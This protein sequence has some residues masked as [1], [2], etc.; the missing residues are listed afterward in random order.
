MQSL[1]LAPT[2]IDKTSYKTLANLLSVI[3]GALVISALA[4]VALP[5]P[6]TPVPITGQT[7][8]I[9]LVSLLWGWKRG[10]SSVGL[11][12]LL[13]FSGA[14]VFAAGASGLVM[15]P[16]FGYLIGMAGA[17]V[18]MGHLADWGM[19]KGFW[20]A[21]LSCYVGSLVTFG[22]GIIGL[23][24]FLPADTLLWSGVI[25]FL[26]GDFIKNVTAALIV[27]RFR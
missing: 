12:L 24:F 9:S 4:Q 15:G 25:P 2:L 21:L 1:A 22:F 18:L 13:G 16:T 11:Y 20:T 5:L 10:F 19:A 26:P 3:M 14:P 17:S 6:W 7:L 27:S 23:S 8:G